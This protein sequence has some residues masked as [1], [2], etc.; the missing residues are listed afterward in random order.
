MEKL[1]ANLTNF[2][3]NIPKNMSAHCLT[4][5]RYPKNSPEKQAM[6]THTKETE[7]KKL[8]FWKQHLENPSAIEI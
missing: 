8:N 4:S 5:T 6:I 3:R 1:S 7:N 2:A